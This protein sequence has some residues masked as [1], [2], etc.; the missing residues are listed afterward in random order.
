MPGPRMISSTAGVKPMAPSAL[1][2]D[3]LLVPTQ[4]GAVTQNVVASAAVGRTRAANVAA[5]ITVRRLGFMR[6][7]LSATPTPTYAAD[8]LLSGGEPP[9]C[10]GYR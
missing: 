3:G 7:S 4:P 1:V 8:R 2:S 6:R 9:T 5:S 10:V